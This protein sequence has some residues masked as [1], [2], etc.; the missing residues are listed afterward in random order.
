MTF[1][2]ELIELLKVEVKTLGNLLRL[3]VEKTDTIVNNHVNNLTNITRKEEILV[4]QVINL[5]NERVKLLDN[6][7]IPIDT[8]ISD[9]IEK[10]SVNE[11][12]EELEKLREELQIVMDDLRVRNEEN[13]KLLQSNLD[14]VDFNINL[15]TSAETPTPYGQGNEKSEGNKIFDRK[16]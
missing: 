14:W 8:P 9:V 3:S 16:V 11:N 5:E 2:D 10:L 1:K 6:W 4:E 13:A 12:T 7:G 15:I